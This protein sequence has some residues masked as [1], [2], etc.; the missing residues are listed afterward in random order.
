MTA[1]STETTIDPKTQLADAREALRL[2][3]VGFAN[4]THNAAQLADAEQAVH[5][6]ETRIAAAHE[7]RIEKRRL[8]DRERASEIVA[9][10][11]GLKPT[12]AQQREREAQIRETVADYLDTAAELRSNVIGAYG[13]LVAMRDRDFGK[14]ML[15]ELGVRVTY[16]SNAVRVG[17]TTYPAFDGMTFLA[18][19]EREAGNRGGR[20]N[21]PRKPAQRPARRKTAS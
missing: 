18:N 7:A 1:N 5:F 21:G 20:L 9:E 8:Q 17:D 4:G 15:A 12:I 6:A 11:E 14:A 13:E 3:R 10:L 2:V 16:A 19:L